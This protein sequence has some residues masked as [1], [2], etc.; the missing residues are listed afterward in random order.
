M[1]TPED[2]EFRVAP[3]CIIEVMRVCLPASNGR[4]WGKPA[5]R[6]RRHKTFYLKP[7][8]FV[9][10]DDDA[11]VAVAEPNINGHLESHR[12]LDG[13]KAEMSRGSKR[14]Q[15]WK[16]A[17]KVEYLHLPESV[18]LSEEA[19]RWIRAS[20]S[21]LAGFQVFSQQHHFSARAVLN[22]RSYGRAHTLRHSSTY[23]L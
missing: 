21:S 8:T 11:V 18:A 6:G 14:Y 1:N 2:G 17:Y 15:G 3:S 4:H 12:H 10:I 16:N 7:T 22:G 13:V 9:S 20:D 19:P 23:G 5:A